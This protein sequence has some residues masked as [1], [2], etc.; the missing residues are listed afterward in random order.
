[1]VK[2]ES[3]AG[4][5]EASE[6]FDKAIQ[7]A[8]DAYHALLEAGVPAEDARY[9]LPNAAESKIVITMNVRE[10]LHFFKP[11][12]LQPRS[13][14]DPRHGASRCWSWRAPRLRSSSPTP[15]RRACAARAR[16]VR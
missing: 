12:L 11:A 14:G 6:A 8:V 10:L 3:I 15:V 2:P 1:M 13:M 4:N 16:R 9:L 5:A 7:A